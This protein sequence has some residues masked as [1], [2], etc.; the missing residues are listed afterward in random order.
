[1]FLTSFGGGMIKEDFKK[2][3]MELNET[4]ESVSVGLKR[5]NQPNTSN[6]ATSTFVM[7]KG[8]AFRNH[9]N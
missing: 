7:L 9:R 8:C 1:M 3:F 5:G 4:Q 6:D 2:R